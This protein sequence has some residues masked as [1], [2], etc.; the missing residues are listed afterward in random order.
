M[1][2]GRTFRTTNAQQ[3][4]RGLAFFDLEET[5][6]GAEGRRPGMLLYCKTAYRDGTRADI[7]FCKAA[8][9]TVA[10]VTIEPPSG[11]CD[12]AK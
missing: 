7:D 8:R 11:A 12:K 2:A 10:A 4:W 3:S 9:S 1:R 5:T 6:A